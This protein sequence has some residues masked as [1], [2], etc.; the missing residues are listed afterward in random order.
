LLG[1][2]K[3]PLEL[4]IIA[5]AE[6]QGNLPPIR[7]CDSAIA[8]VYSRAGIYLNHDDRPDS[9]PIDFEKGGVANLAQFEH[10]LLL[11]RDA[12]DMNPDKPVIFM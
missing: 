5:K 2:W 10:N 11:W 12:V 3:T 7:G 1:C 6:A 4:T 8:Y 9:N